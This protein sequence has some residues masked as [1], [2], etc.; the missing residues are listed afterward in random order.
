MKKLLVVCLFLFLSRVPLLAISAPTNVVNG[1][2][3][4]AVLSQAPWTALSKAFTRRYPP[5]HAA[6]R[7]CCET[8]PWQCYGTALHSGQAQQPEF[9]ASRI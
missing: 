7:C 3:N 2:F 6:G 5:G 9:R 8:A 1:G 4:C